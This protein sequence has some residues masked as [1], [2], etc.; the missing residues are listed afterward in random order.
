MTFERGDKELFVRDDFT[1][2]FDASNT[3]NSRFLQ[4][5]KRCRALDKV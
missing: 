1:V 2:I 3:L 5:L 4:N